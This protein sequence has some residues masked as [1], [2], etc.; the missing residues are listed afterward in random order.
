MKEIFIKD[1]SELKEF[2]KFGDEFKVVEEFGNHIYLY[3]RVFG[4]SRSFWCYELV[5]GKKHKNPDKEV[6]YSYPSSDL[7][8]QY[9]FTLYSNTS[10][11]KIEDLVGKL[12]RE[13]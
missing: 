1:I 5:K 9:G 2:D 11:E 6:V 10:R 13:E 12:K 4:P 8:G 7:W 3:K